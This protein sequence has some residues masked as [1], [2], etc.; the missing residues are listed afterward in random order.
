MCGSFPASHSPLFDIDETVLII[1][2]SGKQDLNLRNPASKAGMK[3]G[4]VSRNKKTPHELTQGVQISF[5]DYLN[6]TFPCIIF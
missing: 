4:F 2:L 3:P 1:R 6:I 5:E